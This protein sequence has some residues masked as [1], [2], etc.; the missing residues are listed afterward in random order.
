MFDPKEK[1]YK[2]KIINAF[3][4]RDMVWGNENEQ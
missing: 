4:M 1:T 3:L 2:G